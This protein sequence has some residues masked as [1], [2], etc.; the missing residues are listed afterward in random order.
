MVGQRINGNDLSGLTTGYGAEATIESRA[1][2]LTRNGE[3]K[4]VGKVVGS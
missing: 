3:I 4:V 2:N 1:Y